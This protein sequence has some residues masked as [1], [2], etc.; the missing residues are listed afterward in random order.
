MKSLSVIFYNF[1]IPIIVFCALVNLCVFVFA[2][3]Q[4]RETR[5]ILY[6]Q[7]SIVYK[8][9]ANSNIIHDHKDDDGRAGA[10]LG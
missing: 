3:L 1:D 9:K 4:I 8:T 5:K 10:D 6:P 7:S 2:L